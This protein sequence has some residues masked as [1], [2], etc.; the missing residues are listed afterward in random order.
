MDR[1]ETNI[2]TEELRLQSKVKAGINCRE[3]IMKYDRVKLDR[4]G[5]RGGSTEALLD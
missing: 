4:I 2:L 1:S 5:W 3:K